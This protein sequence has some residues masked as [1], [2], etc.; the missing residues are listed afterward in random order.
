MVAYMKRYD[1]AYKY[2]CERIR[3]MDDIRFI[4]VNHL[5]PDNSLHVARFD[6]KRFNDLPE[7]ALEHQAAE[8]SRLVS[9][10]LVYAEGAAVPEDIRRAFSSV[11]GSMIHDI[12]NLAGAFGSPTKVLSTEIWAGGRGIST[13]LEYDDQKR[14]VC[15]WVDLPA[16]WDFKET[17][18]VYG[19][20][21]RVIISF[22]TGFSTGLPTTVTLQGMEADYTPW[23][24]ELTWW[25][26]P[27]KLELQHIR[28]CVL[29][30]KRPNTDG[31]E[32]QHDV[33]LVSD[34]VRT[35][36]QQ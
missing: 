26:D 4:Q 36:L 2:A 16:L 22:P 33:G 8:E 34:I 6:V 27:F 19:S 35:Y 13:T 11:R 9:E 7:Q 28:E 24:K 15:S 1:P 12:G 17:M 5:H 21:D 3:E 10:A 23:R 18:E 32:A 31:R 25:E 30:G 14:A 20:H 29:K